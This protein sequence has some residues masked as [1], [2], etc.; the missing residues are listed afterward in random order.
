MTTIQIGDKE[1]KI[2]YSYK[3]TIKS[4]II[5][6][7]IALSD[8]NDSES[9]NG[10]LTL[11]PE[12]L[13]AGLQKCHADEFGCDYTDASKTEQLDKVYELMDDYFD[14]DDGDIQNLFDSLQGELLENGFLSK[15]FQQ[16]KV[17]AKRPKEQK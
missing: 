8:A 14:S 9:V 12:L 3:A 6:K 5:S 13:L 4:G 10:M 7:L 15:M 16:E 1:L 17:K 2:K 11:L